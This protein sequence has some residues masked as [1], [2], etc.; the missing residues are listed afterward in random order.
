MATVKRTP[1]PGA[2]NLEKAL[3][4]LERLQAEVGWNASSRYEDG[5]PVAYVATIQEFGS[6]QQGIESRSFQRTTLDAK[7]AEYA[8]LMGKGGRAVFAGKLSARKMLDSMGLQVAGDMRKKIAD[9]SFKALADSTIAARARRRGVSVESVN[10]DPL[11]DSNVMVN[12]L[13]NQT[14]P[15][16]N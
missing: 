13:T 14:G 1:G 7:Q 8:E 9:G 10:T 2:V 3:R 5:T 11:R 15:R 6:P 4:D 12:T 16:S